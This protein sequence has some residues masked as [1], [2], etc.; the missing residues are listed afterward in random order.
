MLEGRYIIVRTLGR[1]GMGAVYQAL[2]TRLDNIPVAIKEMSTSAVSHGNVQAAIEAFKKEA[3]MLVSLRHPALPRVTDFFGGEKDRWYLVMDYIEGQTLKALVEKRG[4]IPETEVVCWARQICEILDYLHSQEPP[5]IFR[6]LKPANIMLT[7]DGRIKLIDFGIARHFRRDSCADTLAYGSMGFAPP[8]QYGEHQTGPQSDI[9][10]LGATLH[11]LLTGRDPSRNP[12]NFQPPSQFAKVSP[13]M[14]S[15]VMKALQL[16]VEDRP[17]S[18]REMMALLPG[19]EVEV[20]NPAIVQSEKHGTELSSLVDEKKEVKVTASG[21]TGETS[22]FPVGKSLPLKAVEGL[23]VGI[24]VDTPTVPLDQSTVETAP[25]GEGAANF[26][27]TVMN[28]DRN[29]VPQTGYSELAVKDTS[30]NTRF[31]A[32][33]VA[34][35]LL[36][37]AIFGSVSYFQSRN[38]AVLN[39]GFDRSKVTSKAGMGDIQSKGFQKQ[40]GTNQQETNLSDQQLELQGESQKQTEPQAKSEQQPNKPQQQSQSSSQ[41]QQNSVISLPQPQTGQQQS[42]PAVPSQPSCVVDIPELEA[43]GIIQ[44]G[45]GS[46]IDV[47]LYQKDAYWVQ[48]PK[49]VVVEGD[50][51]LGKPYL[52]DNNNRVCYPVISEMTTERSS[53]EFYG[54]KACFPN[55]VPPHSSVR[56][57]AYA[58]GY[59]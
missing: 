41:L 46:T 25:M 45:H 55:G 49:A 8:E 18:A 37:L 22:D 11:Y 21:E 44:G 19:G 38:H 39:D 12:F 33:V 20:H 47:V 50:I 29:F 1:G 4:P 2:D 17:A 16:R 15:A 58:Y 35:V 54:G 53:I 6:D 52:T 42:Q 3:S 28:K 26:S 9:Y 14:E 56:E 27:S 7:P 40:Q 34:V 24:E 48:I 32:P 30:R 57:L 13:R 59:I 23:T 10:A 51:V 5:I 31:V 43:A 36:I